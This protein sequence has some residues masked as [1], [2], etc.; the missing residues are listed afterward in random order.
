MPDTGQNSVKG[1]PATL[2]PVSDVVAAAPLLAWMQPELRLRPGERPIWVELRTGMREA[3]EWRARAAATGLAL[4]AW[5]AL[6]VEIW[7]VANDLEQAL[8]GTQ[9]VEL[10]D[11]ILSTQQ[12]HV[13]PSDQLQVWVR[14]LHAARR[15]ETNPLGDDLPSVALPERVLARVRR[16][17]IE[18][19]RAAVSEADAARA[20][21][22][23][24]AASSFGLTIESFV[25]RESLR[26]ITGGT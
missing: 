16:P 8:G 24:I 3:H 21:E 25:F 6:Q 4:D 14:Q 11:S 23:E 22:L 9:A 18:S 1:A 26:R 7:L 5:L 13:P 19:V 20:L 12:L 2:R 17:V 15:G 10:I